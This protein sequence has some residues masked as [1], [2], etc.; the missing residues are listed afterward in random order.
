MITQLTRFIFATAGALA[1]LAVKNLIDW[2]STIGYPEYF[3]II[4]FVIL[5]CAIGFIFGGIIGRELQRGYNMLESYVRGLAAPDLTAITIGMIVGLVFALLLT[6][7]LRFIQ[8]DGL[9]FAATVMVYVLCLYFGVKVAHIKASDFGQLILRGRG[10]RGELAERAA[11]PVKV[12]DTSTVID[13]RFAEL[14]RAGFLEGPLR[15]P[16]FVLAELQTLA[17]S[18]DDGKRARGRR[19][20]DLLATLQGSEPGIEVF[21]ADYPEIPDVDSKLVRLA[22]DLG[23]T[24]VT[25]D[26]NLTQVARVQGVNALNINEI[27]SALRPSHLPGEVLHIDISRDG[28]EADQGVGYLEDGTMVVVQGGREK[29]GGDADVVVTSVLQTSA[30]RM[31]FSKLRVGA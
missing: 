3:V 8:P 26:Y 29:V 21:E 18:A 20:L 24:V 7:P 14:A 25:I 22:K 23:A 15:L 31:V 30:G 12:L 19:G 10:A 4:L 5:G 9:A 27:A 2:T 11:H 28:K 16:R 13:G 17:D 6:V 1:G